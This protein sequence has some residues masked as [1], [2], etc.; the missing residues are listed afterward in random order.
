VLVLHGGTRDSFDPVP[1]RNLAGL[2]M[3]PIIT[4]IRA[5]GGRKGLVVKPVRY[6]VRGWNGAET[7]PVP[8]ARAALES[9]HKR[10]GDLPVILVGHSMGARTS[11]RV[12]DD[13]RVV[14]VVGMAPWTPGDEPAAQAAGRRLLLLQGDHDTVT[15]PGDSLDYAQRASAAGATVAR[16]VVRRDGHAMLRRWP[17]WHRLAVDLV[18]AEAGVR[19]LSPFLSTAFER[20]AAGDFEVPA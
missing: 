6:R 18:L 8:D 13:P 3:W 19:R 4:T 12:A 1:R 14:A 20:G 5:L 7:S 16:V 11:L 15:P 2:R 17:T 10:Y 9:A